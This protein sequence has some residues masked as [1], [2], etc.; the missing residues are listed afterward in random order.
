VD[1]GPSA[2]LWPSLWLVVAVLVALVVRRRLLDARVPAAVLV[3]ALVAAGVGALD[4]SV[5]VQA[6]VFAVVV[7]A[8][9]G[10][11][12]RWRTLLA[13]DRLPVGVGGNRLVGMTA[14]VVEP[15][16]P[17]RDDRGGQVRVEGETWTAFTTD[18]IV[19]PAGS[20]VVVL[21]VEGTRLRVGTPRPPTAPPTATTPLAR[22]TDTSPTPGAH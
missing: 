3:G 13:D 5:T 1:L 2:A 14:E 19:V 4:G 15:I 21:A 16:A 6:V 18:D 12:W 9:V 20:V 10:V 7:A 11:T 22:P 8:W 17:R